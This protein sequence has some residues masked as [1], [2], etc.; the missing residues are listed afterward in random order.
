MFFLFLLSFSILC[1]HQ[2]MLV[3]NIMLSRETIHYFLTDIINTII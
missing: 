3:H 2:D 1:E